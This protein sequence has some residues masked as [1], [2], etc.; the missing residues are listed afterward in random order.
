MNGASPSLSV[1]EHQA[2]SEG[3][4]SKD[5]NLHFVFGE[6]RLGCWLQDSSESS[7]PFMFSSSAELVPNLPAAQLDLFRCK[8][9]VSH[10]IC[11]LISE[12]TVNINIHNVDGGIEVHR[13]V[14]R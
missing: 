6:N 10:Q 9:N 5:P 3:I 1:S 14:G 8:T 13:C 12:N 2:T 4:E 7:T 11:R